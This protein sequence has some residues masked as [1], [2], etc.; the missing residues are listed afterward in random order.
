MLYISG[1]FGKPTGVLMT[2]GMVFNSSVKVNMA[3]RVTNQ[4]C[5]MTIMPLFHADGIY[6]FAAFIFHFGGKNY[7]VRRFDA[8]QTLALLNDKDIKITHL[9][10]VRTDFIMMS[11][12]EAF[13]Q[14]AF[15]HLEKLFNG[16]SPAPPA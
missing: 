12:L 8:R 5:G 1:T 15:S 3:M 11:E 14:A 7:L 6:D 13:A 9:F 4:S 2:H 16:A 10:G